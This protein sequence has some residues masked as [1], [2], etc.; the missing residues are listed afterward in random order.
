MYKKISDTLIIKI[1]SVKISYKYGHRFI[2]QN[3]FAVANLCFC[4]LNIQAS[5]LA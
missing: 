2:I 5:L 1:V 3:A 4:V